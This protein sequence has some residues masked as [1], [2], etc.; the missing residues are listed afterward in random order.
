[1]LRTGIIEPSNSAYSSSVVMVKKKD[2]SNRFCVDYRKLN[3][4][5]K[6][7]NEPMGGPEALM[8]K[9][10][11]DKFFTKI[12]MSKGYWQ[13]PM[14]ERSKAKTA[15]TVSRGCYQFKRMPFGLMNAAAT[16]NRV[17][18]KMLDGVQNIEHFIDDVLTHTA[19]WDDHIKAL[20]DLFQRVR[21][22]G[23][24]IRPTKC[25]V[26][27]DE[28]EFLGH[29]VS[30]NRIAMNE[31]K[32]MKIQDAAPPKT[33][34]QVRSFLGLTGYYRKFVNN[35]A[36]ITAPLTDLVKKGRPN[37]VEWMEPQQKAFNE[38]KQALGN[39]PILRVPDF[40]RPFIVRS[41]ASNE[42]FGAMLLQEFEDG[43]SPIA[44]ASR[45]LKKNER[46]YCTI[47]KESC[48]GICCKKISVIFVWN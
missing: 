36:H 30:C 40:Q 18:R 20:K 31:D 24:T 39:A 47:E 6:F 25:Y 42:G 1:M 17:M 33:K 4:V 3:A 32:L 44:Y 5:T 35:Y 7:G 29:K 28:V 38:L 22:A 8:V 12:D 9:L 41:D 2:G 23:L 43:L 14:E 16:F 26:G 10:R 11:N 21:K 13:I 27:Y 15:F 19:T 48:N 46:N 45:K 34:T 37:K